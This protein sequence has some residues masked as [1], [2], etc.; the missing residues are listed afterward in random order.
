MTPQ[1]YIKWRRR[2]QAFFLLTFV[3]V[4]T[5]PVWLPGGN[6]LFRLDFI[7]QFLAA[8]GARAFTTS[9]VFAAALLLATFLF[10]RLFCGWVCA[11]GTLADLLDAAM[12]LPAKGERW[13]S[14]KYYLLAFFIGTSAAGLACYWWLAPMN[15]AARIVAPFSLG[16]FALSAF[17]LL[18]A[19]FIGAHLLFGRRAFCRIL[20]PLGAGLG[21]ISRYALF[22]RRFERQACIDCDLCVVHNRSFAIAPTPA[23]YNSAECF[24]CGECVAICPTQ[25][26]SFVP[27]RLRW[28]RRQQ[29]QKPQLQVATAPNLP[30]R[31]FILASSIGLAS[32]VGARAVLAGP[33]TQQTI[34]LRPPGSVNEKHFLNLCIRCNACFTACPAQTLQPAALEHGLLGWG[35]PVLEARAGGCAYEC[36]ACG[37]ACP[38]GAIARLSLPQK[39]RLKLGTAVVDSQRCLPLKGMQACI[40]CQSVCP[41]E[42]IQMLQSGQTSAWG[43]VFAGPVVA[44]DYCT[45]CGLCEAACPVP[46]L[47]AIRIK[48]QAQQPLPSAKLNPAADAIP[49]HVF[50]E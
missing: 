1:N 49:R 39:Q 21:M 27:P 29:P 3:A 5:W 34:P 14:L 20:C 30:R 8:L 10:G 4:A 18:F 44:A 15:W 28:L 41:Y 22:E 13:Q 9:L 12:G 19:L 36:K 16:Y 40:V 47:A 38:T 26:L 11:L 43:D 35:A 42:A 24:R 32:F 6:L 17:V 45:G 7:S 2:S 23:N 37:D 48:P 50:V 46:G 33:S 25:A 31:H